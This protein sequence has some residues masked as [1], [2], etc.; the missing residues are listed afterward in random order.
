MPLVERAASPQMTPLLGFFFFPGFDIVALLLFTASFVPFF[1]FPS[2]PVSS[3]FFVL[4]GFFSFFFSSHFD[5]LL[6]PS[7]LKIF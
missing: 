4:L 3:L 1:P 7:A 5:L 2:F 6:L